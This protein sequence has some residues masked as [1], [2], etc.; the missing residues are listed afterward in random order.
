MA[1]ESKV[2]RLGSTSRSVV[3]SKKREYKE[4]FDGKSTLE[5]PMKPAI[6][7]KSEIKQKQMIMGCDGKAI[8]V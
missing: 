3:N 5:K 8:K 1:L 2:D 7:P 4:D 6:I